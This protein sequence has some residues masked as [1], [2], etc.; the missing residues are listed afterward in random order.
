S[1]SGFGGQSGELGFGF[2]TIWSDPVMIWIALIAVTLTAIS[3]FSAIILLDARENAYCV[4][5][6]RASS[7]LAGIF[8]SILLAWGWGLRMPNSAELTGAVILIA[9]IVLLSVAPRFG[10][11]RRRALAETQ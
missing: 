8:G 5:L 3:I 4:P 1:A 11:A 10:S 7:L 2:I 6:E 9:A